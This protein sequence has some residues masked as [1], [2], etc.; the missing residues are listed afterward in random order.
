MDP[1]SPPTATWT[2]DRPLAPWLLA[3]ILVAIATHIFTFF[4]SDYE[5][6]I[7]A[8]EYFALG[9]SLSD[10]GEL[11][12]PDG[13]RAKRMPLWP[14]TIALAD[15]WQGR[16]LLPHAIFE[17]QAVLSLMSVIF[18]ALTAAKIAG[19][20]AGLLAGLI[21]ALYAP[22]RALQASYLCETMV[23]FLLTGAF[24]AYLSS[25][26][27][28]STASTWSAMTAASVALGLAVLTRA[29]AVVMAIPFAID[30]L[31][32]RNPIGVRIARASALLACVIIA[33]F[34]WGL[35]NERTIGRFTL[36]TIGG[37]N[38]HLGNCDAYAENPGMN[39]AD[40][41]AFDR[42]REEG[43]LSEVEADRRLYAEGRQFALAHPGVTAANALRKTRVWFQSNVTWSA[44]TSLLLILWTL[45]FRGPGPARRFFFG[46]ATAWS[47]IWCIVLDETV[48][49]WANPLFVVPL[50]LIGMAIMKDQIGLRRLL[51]GIVIAQLAIAIVFI[52]L[53]RLRWTIDWVFIIA[54][55]AATARFCDANSDTKQDIESS[56]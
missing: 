35:R 13:C 38:F 16:E 30:T 48:R 31:I 11:C 32:R 24:L 3:V 41:A 6:S 46:V 9:T 44:P 56:V 34:A 25:L 17:I 42:L 23:I 55:A 21:A 29:D 28:K 51:I 20:S 54:I 45:A 4:A 8:K 10:D 40:Y 27:A 52:P 53:E 19:P 7:D 12:L 49:P 2:T 43:G 37:L 14:A 18:I 50:G 5:P 36:S 15:A 26:R 22:Y 1:Q 47:L 39:N 33:S